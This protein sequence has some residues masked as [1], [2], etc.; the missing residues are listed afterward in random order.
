MTDKGNQAC[1]CPVSKWQSWD[2]DL[3][4]MEP[5]PFMP[6]HGSWGSDCWKVNRLCAQHCQ[7][8]Q[9]K[10]KIQSPPLRK[11]LFRKAL[12]PHV[13]R[14]ANKSRQCSQ[15]QSYQVIT[16]LVKRAVYNSNKCK[17]TSLELFFCYLGKKM[18]LSHCKAH[19][20]KYS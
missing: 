18:L 16:I 8:P 12:L 5:R 11:C 14:L 20:R 3:H 10:C 6:E 15:C 19:S 9:R 13:R 17:N 2:S 4:Q 7:A 1:S